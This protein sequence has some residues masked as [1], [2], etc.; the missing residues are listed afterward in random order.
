MGQCGL[1]VLRTYLFM[2]L[3]LASQVS[4]KRNDSAGL[5]SPMDCD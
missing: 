1:K 2:Q 5:L 4:F 3:N